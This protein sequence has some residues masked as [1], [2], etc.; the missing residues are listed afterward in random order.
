MSVVK[1]LK[2]IKQYNRRFTRQQCINLG[3]KYIKLISNKFPDFVYIL[4]KFIS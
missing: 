4:D 2:T 3:E 1:A